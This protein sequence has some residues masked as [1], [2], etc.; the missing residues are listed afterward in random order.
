MGIYY[1]MIIEDSK[2]DKVAKSRSGFSG[3]FQNYRNLASDIKNLSKRPKTDPLRTGDFESLRE[4][5]LQMVEDAK[6]EDRCDYLRK[7]AYIA[8]SQL[9]KLEKNMRDVKNGTPSKYVAVKVVQKQMDGGCTPDKVHK[10]VQWIKSTYL[11][12][13]TK[14]KKEIKAEKKMNESSINFV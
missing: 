5:L 11:P 12:A 13:I 4:W 10:H 6:T 1:D 2:A 14:R 3:L 8:I 7:D 9:E